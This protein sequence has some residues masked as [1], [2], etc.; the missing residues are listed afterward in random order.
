MTVSPA[1]RSPD[2]HTPERTCVAC[3]RRRPQSEFTR[4]TRTAAG[5]ALRPGARVGRGAYVC[6]D[7]PDCWQ[8]G[9]LRRAFGAQAPAIAALLTGRGASDRP[10]LSGAVPAAP[11][12]T[13]HAPARVRDGS[14]RR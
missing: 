5:W 13:P 11:E 12:S 14:H 4:L 8:Q 6:A 3:R 7:S 9:R 1:P 2:R 10:D